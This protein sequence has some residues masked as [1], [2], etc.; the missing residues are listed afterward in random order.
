MSRRKSTLH[1][2]LSWNRS[3]IQDCYVPLPS[4]RAG[5]SRSSPIAKPQ[6]D[7]VSEGIA[8]PRGLTRGGP[9]RRSLADLPLKSEGN[10]RPK[11]APFNR[12]SKLESPFAARAIP[13]SLTQDETSG[14][15]NAET[16]TGIAGA[17]ESENVLRAYGTFLEAQDS[18]STGSNAFAKWVNAGEGAAAAAKLAEKTGD[19]VA[20]ASARK[21]LKEVKRWIGEREVEMIV[22]QVQAE[23][24]RG[25]IDDRLVDMAIPQ[26]LQMESLDRDI[27]KLLMKGGFGHAADKLKALGDGSLLGTPRQEGDWDDRSLATTDTVGE[28][29]MFLTN[30]ISRSMTAEKKDPQGANEFEQNEEL[31]YHQAISQL[32]IQVLV[33]QLQR[34]AALPRAVSREGPCQPDTKNQTTLP[35][36]NSGVMPEQLPAVIETLLIT[37]NLSTLDLSGNLLTDDSVTDLIHSLLSST[38]GSKLEELNLSHNAALTWRCV[39]GISILLGSGDDEALGRIRVLSKSPSKRAA[40]GLKR[41]KLECVNL[42]DKGARKLAEPLRTNVSLKELNL[43]RCGIGDVGGAVFGEIL[44]DNCSI[45]DLI[46]GWNAFGSKTAAAFAHGLKLNPALVTLDIADSG[47]TDKDCAVLLHG[48]LAHESWRRL[49]FSGNQLAVGSCLIVG[50]LLE[51]Y[52]KPQV[53]KAMKSKFE[54]PEEPLVINRWIVIDRN[55]ITFQGLRYLFSKLD[56][57]G[58]VKSRVQKENRTYVLVNWINLSIADCLFSEGE[59]GIAQT[60]F[61]FVDNS[62]LQGVPTLF[63]ATNKS[64]SEK[65]EKGKKGGKGKKKGGKSKKKGKGKKGA[66]DVNTPTKKPIGADAKGLN[67]ESPQGTYLL[68]LGHPVCQQVLKEFVKMKRDTTTSSGKEVMSFCNVTLNGK[69]IPSSRVESPE[70]LSSLEQPTLLVLG[71]DIQAPAVMESSLG[72]PISSC[73]LQWCIREMK[74]VRARE[75]WKGDIMEAICK[76]FVLKSIEV[77]KLLST[78]DDQ[79]GQDEKIRAGQIHACIVNLTIECCLKGSQNYIQYKV[80]WVHESHMFNPNV[81]NQVQLFFTLRIGDLLHF[82]INNPTGRHCFNLSRQMDRIMAIRLRDKAIKALNCGDS[83]TSPWRNV[84]LSGHSVTGD[85]A[86]HLTK[87]CLP[88]QG[89]LTFDYVD[90]KMEFSSVGEM[91]EEELVQFLHSLRQAQRAFA[92]DLQTIRQE[93]LTD[94]RIKSDLVFYQE[95]IPFRVKRI[96]R[97]AATAQ[98]AKSDL[99]DQTQHEQDIEK[100][101]WWV[102]LDFDPSTLLEKVKNAERTGGSGASG[103]K[104]KGKKGKKGKTAKPE[105]IEM[106][107]AESLTEQLVKLKTRDEMGMALFAAHDRQI[108]LVLIILHGFTNGPKVVS[109]LLSSIPPVR[110]VRF[111]YP[112]SEVPSLAL[113][114][115][116]RSNVF[117][118]MKPEVVSVIQS[119]QKRLEEA[120]Q[121][122]SKAIAEVCSNTSHSFS[123]TSSQV[124]RVLKAL[125]NGSDRIRA[126]VYLWSRVLDRANLW[127]VLAELHPREQDNIMQ[128]LGYIYV[129]ETFEKSNGVHFHL[130][131]MNDEHKDA[132][133]C[134]LKFATRAAKLK[135]NKGKGPQLT[136]IKVDGKE[137]IVDNDKLDTLTAKARVLDFH[138]CMDDEQIHRHMVRQT[139]K[140]QRWWRRAAPSL[141]LLSEQDS[142]D[143]VQ[144]PI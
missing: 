115:E 125:G 117:K 113:S 38:Q 77:A 71:F 104:G 132:W 28:E 97:K 27:L 49:D 92:A 108:L 59:R 20:L 107:K 99:D 9:R 95:A 6:S 127:K 19:Q 22:G 43:R 44:E 67:L 143:E 11:S 118:T 32:K 62:S 98:P 141:A 130:D 37:P 16:D 110:A 29:D 1:E 133:K 26:Q 81:Q 48:F 139:V 96:R 93:F 34:R 86:G 75:T 79:L 51:L 66:A 25:D 90:H 30:R 39:D 2:K 23:G 41:L 138:Y 135:E 33:G 134:I 63:D 15:D 116:A 136:H 58:D 89:T 88:D 24:I 61:K 5:T 8:S 73:V 84:V 10:N 68:E 121:R 80:S 36:S 13:I 47:I 144:K 50:H 52:A 64:N 3:T 53:Q 69:P 46:L 65:V 120:S 14:A 17:S 72:G 7:L 76:S 131:L 109:E 112:S 21:A 12:S 102:D 83:T 35:L 91:G 105:E 45:T 57:I 78:F 60:P 111:L 87:Y 103:K 101:C 82:Q 106:A 74:E 18:A 124:Q 126:F 122:R 56:D 128:R 55:P 70:F 31:T 100:R 85:M 119:T 42:G 40:E 114:I 54:N 142:D 129:W 94:G 123:I 137:V 140:I 4:H